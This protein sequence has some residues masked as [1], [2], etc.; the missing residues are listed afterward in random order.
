MRKIIL[1]LLMVMVPTVVMARIT[2]VHVVRSSTSTLTLGWDND[3]TAAAARV[4]FAAGTLS[5]CA[6]SS[7]QSFTGGCF[8]HHEV[9]VTGLMI[10]QIYCL[11]P[12]DFVCVADYWEPGPPIEARTNLIDT[13]TPTFS[14]SPTNTLTRTQTATPTKTPTV[15]SSFTNSPTKTLTATRTVTSTLTVTS[16]YTVTI[17]P[18]R[19]LT[20][21]STYTVTRTITG[22]ATPT[23]TRT[24]TPT[25]T[26]TRTPTGTF[27][28]TAT[29]TPTRSL[30][31]TT[32]G[33]YTE[34]Q[35]YTDSPSPTDSPTSTDSPTPT[36]TDSPTLTYS[37]TLTSTRT[38]T[39]T[40][41]PTIS[42]TFTASPT[43]PAGVFGYYPGNG[44]NNSNPG[45]L[46]DNSTYG[47]TLTM[48]GTVPNPS[49]PTP[50]EGA[51]WL[52]YQTAAIANYLTAPIAVFNPTNFAVEFMADL[53]DNQGYFSV[54]DTV[55]G[56]RLGVVTN[57]G[58]AGTLGVFLNGSVTGVG[59]NI[60]QS[61]VTYGN[62]KIKVTN[63]GTTL[64]LYVDNV[65]GP[66]QAV[67]FASF[68]TVQYV[69]I[70]YYQQLSRG[71]N[72]GGIDAI[73]FS[74]PY[75]T[76]YYGP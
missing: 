56:N 6:Y 64:S 54:A 36:P 30:T 75:T 18:S 29:R 57:T 34:T 53:E 50:P 9:T 2:N 11:K 51:N 13:P 35:T 4:S 70:G 55:N 16:T 41:S 58:F 28:R 12:Y 72:V 74:N 14:S 19:T 42:P 73:Q 44:T 15:T 26:M 67:S 27:T 21:T 10:D 76:T 38:S 5:G 20:A 71:L 7:G 49:S 1:A 59:I 48:V 8:Y 66:T 60:A 22:T 52:I 69:R 46:T 39:I 23:A 63:D 65:L 25:V 17:T 45:Q 62:H 24:V 68:G 31:A 32:T 37:P 33:T 43:P 61:G 40:V 3:I 47:R